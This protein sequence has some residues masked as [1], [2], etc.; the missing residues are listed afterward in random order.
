MPAVSSA[1]ASG[2]AILEEKLSDALTVDYEGASTLDAHCG[3][4]QRLANLS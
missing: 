3:A 2:R 1:F 4:A